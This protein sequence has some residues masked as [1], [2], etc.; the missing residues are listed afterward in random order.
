[1]S[2]EMDALKAIVRRLLL[3]N[4]LMVRHVRL[5][6][7]HSGVAGPVLRASPPLGGGKFFTRPYIPRP[8][9]TRT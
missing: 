6:R 5:T 1:M 3:P 2:V 8:P 4:A 7:R 9:L